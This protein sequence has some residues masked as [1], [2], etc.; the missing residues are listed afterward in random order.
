MDFD[1]TLLVVTRLLALQQ[2]IPGSESIA[3]INI[4]G[5]GAVAVGGCEEKNNMGGRYMA[6]CGCKYG[7]PRPYPLKFSFNLALKE[8]VV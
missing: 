4:E 6:V 1:F 7:L 8:F 2:K 3:C 5:G